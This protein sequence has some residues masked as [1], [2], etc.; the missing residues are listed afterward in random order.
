MLRNSVKI[1]C[2]EPCSNGS[3]D[4]EHTKLFAELIL[5]LLLMEVS[6]KFNIPF[7]CIK[8]FFVLILI[9][10]EVSLK[11]CLCQEITAFNPCSNGSSQC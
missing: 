6:L 9:L 7:F 1:F 11:F 8:S 5:I 4:H 10:E 2:F 3:V